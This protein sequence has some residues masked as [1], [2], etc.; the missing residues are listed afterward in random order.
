MAVIEI[1]TNSSSQAV[2][3]CPAS[4]KFSDQCINYPPQHLNLRKR[5]G[6]IRAG[7]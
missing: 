6:I 5:K 1:K 2:V 3:V 4:V 7:S